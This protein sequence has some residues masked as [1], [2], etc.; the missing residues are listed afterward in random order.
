M[1]TRLDIKTK[2]KSKLFAV[3]TSTYFTDTRIEKQIDDSY[4]TVAAARQW[5]DIKKGFVTATEANIDNYDYPNNCQS[6]SIFK[7][8]VDGVSTYEKTDFEDFMME[9]ELNPTVDKKMFAEYG[10]QIFI[11]PTPLTDGTANLIFW[12]VIQAAA[13]TNDGDVTMFTDWSDVLNEAI[14]EDAYGNLIQNI[15]SQKSLAAITNS[16]KIIT[17]EWKKI[18]DRLQRKLTNRPQFIVPDFF[19]NTTMSSD[20]GKFRFDR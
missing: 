4:V 14:E 9:I 17:R 3:G 11:Y 18:A 15:D 1:R 12:G 13:M 19:S 5:P 8:S 6:E 16:E 2:L 10:R 20:V 7:I